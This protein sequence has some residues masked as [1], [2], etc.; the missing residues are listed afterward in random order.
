MAADKSHEE[1]DSMRLMMIGSFVIFTG[2]NLA[3]GGETPK[4]MK[5]AGKPRAV[6][7]AVPGETTLMKVEDPPAGLVV[8]KTSPQPTEGMELVTRSVNRELRD[9]AHA[10]RSLDQSYSLR[11]FQGCGAATAGSVF[12]D[13]RAKGLQ[14]PENVVVLPPPPIVL[15]I[16]KT[17]CCCEDCRR[18]WSILDECD[19]PSEQDSPPAIPPGPIPPQPN[20]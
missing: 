1:R 13:W 20:P 6:W 12:I 18:E 5:S 14:K 4:E 17:R 19:C 3:Y 2:L 16:P 7:I 11:G 9:V 10:L 8:R 15:G